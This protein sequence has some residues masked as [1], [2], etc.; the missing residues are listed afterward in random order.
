MEPGHRSIARGRLLAVAKPQQVSE[1]I[2]G[3]GQLGMESIIGNG[4]SGPGLHRPVEHFQPA[5]I[6]R[7][8]TGIIDT[9]PLDC[10]AVFSIQTVTQGNRQWSVHKYPARLASIVMALLKRALTRT[11]DAQR[12]DGHPQAGLE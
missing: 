6:E 9:Q 12:S 4:A 11:E 7:S 2:A 8:G 1:I 10:K 5:H 3:H